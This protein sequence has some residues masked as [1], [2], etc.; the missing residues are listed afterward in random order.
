MDDS[1]NIQADNRSTPNRN[2]TFGL[3]HLSQSALSHSQKRLLDAH[4]FFGASLKV[5]G[6]YFLTVLQGL[7]ARHLQGKNTLEPDH[8]QD[9]NRNPCEIIGLPHI[10]SKFGSTIKMENNM[11]E[12]SSVIG[13]EK[14][15]P[16]CSQICSKL[17]LIQSRLVHNDG[18]QG[19]KLQ[20]DNDST[21]SL[22]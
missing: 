17:F 12:S 3:N 9:S 1:N 19:E 6:S 18:K 13:P 4:V 8:W 14:P 7:P 21:F 22:P 5:V 2:R 11:S 10:I 15:L 16:V 20:P